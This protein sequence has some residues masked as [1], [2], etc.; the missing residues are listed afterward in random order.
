MILSC[1]RVRWCLCVIA[2]SENTVLVIGENNLTVLNMKTFRLWKKPNFGPLCCFQKYMRTYGTEWVT[3]QCPLSVSHLKW[4]TLWNS[5]EAYNDP[6]LRPWNALSQPPRTCPRCSCPIWLNKT[7]K[8]VLFYQ[9]PKPEAL[10]C[11][12]TSSPQVSLGNIRAGFL[13]SVGQTVSW[14]G[15]IRSEVIRQ[16]WLKRI[17]PNMG[18][19]CGGGRLWLLEPVTSCDFTS[20]AAQSAQLCSERGPA[21]GTLTLRRFLESIFLQLLQCKKKL[22]S[23]LSEKEACKRSGVRGALK[24]EGFRVE[25]GF[26]ASLAAPGLH[27]QVSLGTRGRDGA[28]WVPQHLPPAM[29]APAL[30]PSCG[31]GGKTPPGFRILIA[32]S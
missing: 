28:L 11:C 20:A 8:T 18:R 22:P 16:S 31:G 12:E 3:V 25:G 21:K 6:F 10:P 4:D 23:S 29:A 14:Q 13:R 32:V 26:S 1:D 5:G 30:G 17:C 27:K 9:N 24:W 19:F 7:Q 15:W 2:V